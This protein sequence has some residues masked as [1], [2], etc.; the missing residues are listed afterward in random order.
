MKYYKDNVVRKL[1]IRMSE[2]LE[3]ENLKFNK[4]ETSRNKTINSVYRR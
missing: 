1:D 2:N 3:S 4:N